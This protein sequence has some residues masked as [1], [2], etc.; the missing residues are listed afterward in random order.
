MRE[1]NL[2]INKTTLPWLGANPYGMSSLTTITI[3]QAG[4]LSVLILLF[5]SSYRYRLPPG[6]PGNVVGEFK[7]TS[8]PEVFDKWRRKYGTSHSVPD[9]DHWSNHGEPKKVGYS[10]SS[11]GRGL[12]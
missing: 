9:C 2:V 5:V 3:L 1:P 6:P 10:P 7:N 12:S 4:A 8:M 11:S